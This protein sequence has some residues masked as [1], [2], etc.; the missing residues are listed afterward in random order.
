LGL[1]ADRLAGIQ[2]RGATTEKLAPDKDGTSSSAFLPTRDQARYVCALTVHNRYPMPFIN[3]P[4]DKG[5]VGDPERALLPV[6]GFNH[7]LG[8]ARRFDSPLDHPAAFFALLGRR[9][10]GA[11]TVRALISPNNQSH[12]KKK[13]QDQLKQLFHA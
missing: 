5:F 12:G 11:F 6:S 1:F 7:D 3:F 2:P 10:L 8:T 13:H 9:I 4:P